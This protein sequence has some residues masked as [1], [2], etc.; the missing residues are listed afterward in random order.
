MADVTDATFAT[1][2]LERSQ[3]RPIVV[4]LWAP[5]CGPCRTLGPIL[6]KVVGATGGEVELA[7]VNVDENPQI[8][9]M[10]QVQG[11]PAVYAVKDAKVVDGFVGAQGEAFVAD[12]VARLL[13]TEEETEIDR[14]IAAGDE[15]SLRQALE[16]DPANA[17]IIVALAAVLIDAGRGE[18]ALAL[19]EKIPETAETR[20]LAAIARTGGGAP[21]GDDLTAKLDNLLDRVRDDDDARQEYLDLL[22]LLGPDDPRT[23]EYRRRLSSALF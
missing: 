12:F 22:E 18:D 4:D 14:L 15:A 8:A 16:L 5:W 11:I 1:D 20:H 23:A 19:L 6:E 10:F 17:D 3:V 7:K 13:P 9:Q 21:A 2:V